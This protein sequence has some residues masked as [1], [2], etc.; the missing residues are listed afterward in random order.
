MSVVFLA[1]DFPPSTGGI[2]TVAYELALAI[3]EKGEDVGVV[4]VCRPGA[5][6]FDANCPYPIARVPEASKLQTATNLCEGVTELIG[7]IA[8]RPRA[9]VATKWFPEGL[10]AAATMKMKRPCVTLI[11]H[12][13]EFRINGGNPLKWFLQ[14]YIL[15]QINLCIAG[16]EWTAGEFRKAGV[17]PD[18][19]RVVNYGVR[20]EVFE[21]AGD[22]AGLKTE[23]GIGDEPVL[24]T[25]GR[26][27]ARKGHVDVLRLLPRVLERVG[28]VTYVVVGSGPEEQML[29]DA[30][31]AYGVAEHV[32]FVGKAD[33]ERLPDYYHLCDAFVMPT[34]DV[35]GDPLEGFGVVYLEANAAGKPTIATDCGGVAD[36]VAD[37]V[38]G[39]LVRP[40]DDDALVDAMVQLTS[41]R[42]R[43]RT[44]GDSGRDRVM[45]RFTW[46]KVAD[47]FLAAL[48]DRTGR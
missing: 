14:K 5:D 27:V 40:D 30:A 28:D 13:R 6:E 35:P 44:L 48:D 4:T 43:A 46:D 47:R 31:E 26:L 37:G 34:K 21:R 18:R 10:A 11:G 9:I 42:E 36:A 8:E 7:Q 41:D 29:H 22:V 12:G 1:A 15:R 24:L 2:Q 32:R 39:L 16:S 20:P 3:Q 33:P 17:R 38:S 23:L 45:S 19:I 25:V